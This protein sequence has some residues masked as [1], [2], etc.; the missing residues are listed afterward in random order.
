MFTGDGSWIEDEKTGEVMALKEE[1]GMY[2]LQMWVRTG[3][4]PS[5]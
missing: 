4:K 2:T 1:G 5:F 3:T